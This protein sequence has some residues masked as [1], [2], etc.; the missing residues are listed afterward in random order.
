M[1]YKAAVIVDCACGRR[2]QRTGVKTLKH[3]IGF[4]RCVCGHVIERWS[5]RFRFAFEPEEGP[6]PE[7]IP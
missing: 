6:R 2:Y 3:E 5:G 7:I 4:A 1:E